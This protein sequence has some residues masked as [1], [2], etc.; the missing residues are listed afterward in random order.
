M[1]KWTITM[2]IKPMERDTT[3]LNKLFYFRFIKHIFN[4]T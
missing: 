2:D 3:K 4:M 1:H